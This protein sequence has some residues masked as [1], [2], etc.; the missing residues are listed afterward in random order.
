MRRLQQEFLDRTKRFAHRVVDVAE[1]VAA[2][3]RAPRI[4][5]RIID[6]MVGSGTSVGAN[7]READEA[8]SRKDFTKSL[9]VVLKELGET[10]F[11]LEFVGERGWV[12]SRRLTE[13]LAESEELTRICNTVVSRTKA[14][15]RRAAIRD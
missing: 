6:Q 9:G 13:L 10:R 12:P 5:D 4:R 7:I 2:G 15:D 11:W 8:I 3:R 14:A 1:A